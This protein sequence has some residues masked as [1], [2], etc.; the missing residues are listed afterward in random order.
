MRDTM[1]FLLSYIREVKAINCNDGFVGDFR[2]DLHICFFF[3]LHGTL[4]ILLRGQEPIQTPD[5]I[6][7]YVAAI[8][9]IV[10]VKSRGKG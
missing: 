7:S 6:R 5:H 1:C 4:V 9:C 8:T 2:A 10:H 3:Y